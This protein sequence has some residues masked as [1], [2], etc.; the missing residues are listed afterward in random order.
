V[1]SI[2]PRPALDRAALER[3]LARAA[4]LQSRDSGE[5]GTMLTDDQILELGREVGLAPDAIRQAIAEE[6]GK[7]VVPDER[8]AIGSWFGAATISAARII[9]GTV[10]SALEAIDTAMRGNLPFDISR[11]FPDRMQ[12]TPKRGFFDLMRSQLSTKAEGADLRFAEE[13]AA[14]VVA[15]NEQRVHVRLDAMLAAARRQAVSQSATAA[16]GGAFLA[17]M[18]GITGAGIPLAIPV[19]AA[20]TAAGALYARDR[21]RRMAVRVGV[22]LEQLLD[23]LEFGPARHKGGLIDK[24]LG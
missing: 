9:P 14:S 2:V 24:L 6:R 22:A 7:V 5:I 21:Y 15:V 1:S 12:W 4:E 13:V 16:V 8:G 3:V 11:R 10:G 19:F 18:V 23:R 17:F 20:G